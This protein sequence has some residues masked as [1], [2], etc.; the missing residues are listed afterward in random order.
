[1]Y[2]LK[3]TY[4]DE[5]IRNSLSGSEVDFI[6]YIAR[7][8]NED[9]CV[10]SVYYKDVCEHI[11]ISIQKYYDILRSLEDKQLIR[12]EKKNPSDTAVT[13]IGNSFKD[14]TY[15]QGKTPGYLNVIKNEF[16]SKLFRKMKAGA[17]L[18]YLYSQRF[19]SGKHMLLENFY[20][21]FCRL[22][23]VARKT[24]QRYIHEL[25]ENKLLFIS[26]KRNKTYN[27]EMTFR[28]STVL[29]SKN[30]LL[31]NENSLYVE[32]IADM[33]ARNFKTALP[34][35]ADGEKGIRRI[36]HQIAGLATQKRAGD[37]DDFASLIVLAIKGSLKQQKTEK[38][39]RPVINAAL[40]NK[41]IPIAAEQRILTKYGLTN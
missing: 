39:K 34:E 32:N 17:K 23:N 16:A 1:M 15:I 6:L 26:K 13:L 10:E 7:Y 9:G 35:S 40:V 14:I 2:K 29:Y 18:F 12:C 33:I 22:F 5:M 3:N 27:Y 21:E 31:P 20:A 25:K 36:L 30:T 38:K 11:G 28:P 4:I 41:W 24:L 8:Q 37:Y 19:L